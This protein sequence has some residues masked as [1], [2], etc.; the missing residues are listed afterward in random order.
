MHEPAAAPGISTLR[1][2]P[3]SSAITACPWHLGAARQVAGT[4]SQWLIPVLGK[5]AGDLPGHRD[6]AWG[7]GGWWGG[8]A[9]TAGTQS[10]R[11]EGEGSFTQHGSS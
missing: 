11:E 8:S 2:C 1:P 3:L 9:P 7:A 10:W 5:Q 6:T 4:G